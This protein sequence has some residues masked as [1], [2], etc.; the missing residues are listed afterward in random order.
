VRALLPHIVCIL[1]EWALTLLALKILKAAQVP[2]CGEPHR[3]RD[4]RGR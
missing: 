4:A 3:Y 2:P 1:V